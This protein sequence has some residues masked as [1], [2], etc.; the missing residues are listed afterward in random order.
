MDRWVISKTFTFAVVHF[1]VAFGVGW[2][3]S[4][5]VRVGGLVATVEPIVNT[6]AY[7]LHEKVWALRGARAPQCVGVRLH[8]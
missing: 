4:G 1:A 7:H 5:D 2:L 3:V 8:A 6:I